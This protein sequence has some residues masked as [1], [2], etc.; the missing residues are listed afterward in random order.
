MRKRLFTVRAVK[1]WKGLS[2][3][4]VELL[5][6]EIYKTQLDMTLDSLL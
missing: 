5:S 1:Q 6:L 2:R 3:K 4:A